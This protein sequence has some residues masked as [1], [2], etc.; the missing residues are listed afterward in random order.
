[1]VAQGPGTIWE[2]WP[3][4]GSNSRNH[5]MF[6]ASIGPYLYTIA[7]L[8]PSTWTVAEYQ[9]QAARQEEEEVREEEEEEE[10][11]TM[12]LSP[13]PHAVQVLRH[14]SA[15]VRT[16]CGEVAVDWRLEEEKNDE[17]SSSFTMR[18]TVPHNCGSA[19]LVLHTPAA[20]L[21]GSSKIVE[22]LCV[23]A[24]AEKVMVATAETKAAAE[25]PN[26]IRSVRVAEDRTTVD[27]IVGGGLIDLALREC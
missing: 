7:G 25:L 6:T 17:A 2:T 18:A 14:A 12:H 19:R 13:Q 21:D 11:V 22:T 23:H 10:G 24:G 1:M 8:D 5:P 16:Q 26:N 3:E 15:R 9:A 4:G 20:F 27:V